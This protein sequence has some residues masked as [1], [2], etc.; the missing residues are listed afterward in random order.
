MVSQ[1]NP[2][3]IL[4]NTN[5]PTIQ[6]ISNMIYWNKVCTKMYE[7]NFKFKLSKRKLFSVE[8]EQA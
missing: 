4:K 2:Y 5:I 7:I 8:E 1:I 6:E 3:M